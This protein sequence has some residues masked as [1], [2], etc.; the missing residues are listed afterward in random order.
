VDLDRGHGL[1]FNDSTMTPPLVNFT[2]TVA[3]SPQLRSPWLLDMLSLYILLTFVVTV[4]LVLLA[5][6][7]VMFVIRCY[8]YYVLML[9]G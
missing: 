6:I 2:I 3:S 5:C 9:L 7:V 1:I 8:Y 4:Y